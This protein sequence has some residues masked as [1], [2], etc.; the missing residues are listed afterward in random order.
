[1]A[2]RLGVVGLGL[3]AMVAGCGPV[4]QD[5][6]GLG[7]D[8]SAPEV[9]H[10]SEIVSHAAPESQPGSAVPDAQISEY[11]RRVFQDRDGNFWFGTNDDGV[12]RFD[13]TT[14]TYFNIGEGFGGWAVREILQDRA[15][16]VWFGTNG[17]VSRY[18]GGK[19]TNYKIGIMPEDNEVWSMTIDSK[20]T[21]W[22]GAQTGLRRFD[23]KAFVPV[24]LPGVWVEKTESRFSPKVVFGMAEDREGNMWFGTDGEG[25][26]RYDGLKFTS[27][28][29]KQGLGGNLVRCVY[30][31]RRGRVWVGSDG[32]GVTCFDGDVMRTY[33]SKD[34]LGNDRVFGVL[35]DRAG[36]MWFSTL[37]AG[38]TRYDGKA[39]TLFDEASGLTRSHV[40]SM[41]E[42][43][44]GTLW[45]GCSGGLFRREGERFVNV[46]RRG[47][48]K[49]RADA[50]AVGGDV[51][52]MESFSRLI[53]GRW[54]M[55]AQSG[56][57]MFDTWR[58]GPGRRSIRVMTDGEGADGK[59][60][61]SVSVYYWHPGRKEIRTLSVQP[62]RRGVNEGSITFDGQRAEG[63]AD[64]HQTG[65][66]REMGLRWTF[67]G[68][69]T[70]RDAL[71][72]KG[73]QGYEVLVEWER[74][75][76]SEEGAAG[77]G[78]LD[79]RGGHSLRPSALMEPLAKFLGSVWERRAGE[80]D[81]PVAAERRAGTRTTFEYVAYADAI[82]GRVEEIGASGARA[83][84]MDVY[85]YHH[86]GAGVLR[87][88]ALG[89]DAK[90]EAVV[91]EGNIT[92]SKDGRSLVF[93]LKATSAGGAERM[94]MQLEFDADASVRQRV[95][96]IKGETRALMLDARHAKTP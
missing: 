87:Y 84:A 18:E 69:D 34:G 12:A 33:T 20:G 67:E 51:N 85:L 50:D 76:V 94:E 91:Y 24:V 19:F 23:G 31:D 93:D 39:F 10:P 59:P 38:A 60:W 78:V 55:T 89:T 9:A 83:H 22:V 21:I 74:V 72:E 4:R 68:G 3:V 29:T 53:G 81:V 7:A 8:D 27:Y 52:P 28:T 79:A 82:Y 40:Q 64:L 44:E 54:Q 41:H 61:R 36:D 48:W 16:A 75:R 45:F 47:P 88:L 17:G 35:E 70:Y 96:S 95:W 66:K 25:V 13:G 71:L 63:F 14:L 49:A 86:T 1:M 11:V 62:F 43:R 80:S 37:G 30:V 65:D 32:G 73:P 56:T 77:V 57:S 26:H 42:D 46:M 15:G 2:S 92:P 90:G 58:W 6:G 5:A